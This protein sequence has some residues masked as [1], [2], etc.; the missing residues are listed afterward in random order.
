[1]ELRGPSKTARSVAAHRLTFRRAPASF[2]RPREDERLSADVAA[3]IEIRQAGMHRYLR[4][5]TEFFDDVVVGAITAGCRQL[6]VLG[7]GYDGRSL[8]YANPEVRF[9]EV[10]LEGTQADKRARLARLGIDDAHVTYVEA[11]FAH[12]DVAALLDTAGLAGTRTTFLLE[13]VLPYLPA[14]VIESLLAAIAGPAG[15]DRAL[16]VSAGVVHDPFDRAAADRIGEFRD[17]VGALGEPVRSDLDEDAFA[18]ALA[19]TGWRREEVGNP[20][21]RERRRR[22]GFVVA[23]RA[24]A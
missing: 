7:A 9:F 21:E 10:D 23:R 11:D 20:D 24:A 4:A 13:G 12:D 17:R 16:A 8:R 1:V 14:T 6:V 15:S 19:R 2:G 3:G 18:E 5:R 22:L